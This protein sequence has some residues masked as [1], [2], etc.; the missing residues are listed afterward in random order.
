MTRKEGGQ[1]TPKPSTA[2][3]EEFAQ[4]RN[5]SHQEVRQY[6]LEKKGVDIEDNVNVV[7]VAA[8]V[9][10]ALVAITSLLWIKKVVSWYSKRK[11]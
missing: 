10:I 9:I 6:I 2:H 4:F 11:E 8:I 5:K 1:Q 3:N 7:H